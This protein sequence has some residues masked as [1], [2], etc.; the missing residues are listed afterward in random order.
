MSALLKQ[1]GKVRC[2]CLVCLPPPARLLACLLAH[3][4]HCGV[5]FGCSWQSGHTPVSRGARDCKLTMPLPLLHC[6]G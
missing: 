1:R 5:I 2:A 4:P 3:L 6:S